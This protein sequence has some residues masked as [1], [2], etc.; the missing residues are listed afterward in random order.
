MRFPDEVVERPDQVRDYLPLDEGVQA[1]RLRDRHLAR[2]TAEVRA[3][4]R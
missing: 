1:P 3:G 4:A 2:P